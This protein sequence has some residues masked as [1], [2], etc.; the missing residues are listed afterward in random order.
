MFLPLAAAGRNRCKLLL[1]HL[2]MSGVRLQISRIAAENNYKFNFQNDCFF[3]VF[4]I[5]IKLV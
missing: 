4:R 3:S 5:I 1:I 2:S